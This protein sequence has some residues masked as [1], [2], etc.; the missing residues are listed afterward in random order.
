MRNDADVEGLGPRIR[1]LRTEQGLTQDRLALRARVDQSGLSKLE[2][3]A[4][5][6]MGPVPLTR[7][8]EV[9]GIT[10]DELVEGT[11]YGLR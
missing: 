4:S 7:I 2:R 11:D 9:L 1:R 8:A 3:Q 5:K 6:R 10:F